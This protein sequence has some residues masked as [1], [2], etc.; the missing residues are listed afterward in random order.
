MQ[1]VK[2]YISLPALLGVTVGIV[3]AALLLMGALQHTAAH[4]SGLRFTQCDN[5]VGMGGGGSHATTSPVYL[6]VGTLAA[7]STMG[8]CNLQQ[9]SSFALNIFANASTTGSSIVWVEQYSMDGVDWYNADAN[10]TAHVGTTTNTYTPG[11]AGRSAITYVRT[12]TGANYVRIKYSAV[13][14]SSSVYANLVPNNTLT[15]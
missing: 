11:V 1:K 14:A 6:P 3:C 10:A 7:T 2:N 8:P 9:A 15:N 4:A 12:P 5:V 13:T